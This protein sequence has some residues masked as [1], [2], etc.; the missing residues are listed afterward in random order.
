MYRLKKNTMKVSSDNLDQMIKKSLHIKT[1]GMKNC[2]LL[3][4][5]YA[6]SLL[7]KMLS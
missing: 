6:N 2:N 7:G 5:S 4:N 3:E 1:C